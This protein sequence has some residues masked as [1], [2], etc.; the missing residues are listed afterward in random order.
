MDDTGMSDDDDD[1]LNITMT[2][3]EMY[4]LKP[5]EPLVRKQEIFLN[6][7]IE[8]P[9][10]KVRLFPICLPLSNFQLNGTS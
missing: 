6:R 4:I 7:V 9:T 8:D 5:Q 2:E 3:T 10:V 1:L